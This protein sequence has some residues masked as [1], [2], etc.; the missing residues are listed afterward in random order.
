MKYLGIFIDDH[1]N[2]HAN[3]SAISTKLSSATG[4]LYKIRHFVKQETLRMIYYGI[5]QNDQL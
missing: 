3:E 2:W 5:L 1:L 4:M